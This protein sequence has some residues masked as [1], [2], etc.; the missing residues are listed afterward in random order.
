MCQLAFPAADTPKRT[1]QRTE[2]RRL[3]RAK[4]EV[5]GIP[6]GRV[7]FTIEEGKR[8]DNPGGSKFR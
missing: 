1:L 7:E 8:M 3:F 6:V 2:T 4:T 5:A